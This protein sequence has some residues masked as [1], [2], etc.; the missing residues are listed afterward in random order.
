M[1]K[2]KC[3]RIKFEVRAGVKI[4]KCVTCKRKVLVKECVDGFEDN[5]DVKS[6][7]DQIV[8]IKTDFQVLSKRLRPT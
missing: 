2:N 4:A 1:C 3:C 7:D 5:I 6:R 8:T